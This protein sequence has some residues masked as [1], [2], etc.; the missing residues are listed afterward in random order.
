MNKYIQKLINE[1]FN[2]GNMD[3]NDKQVRNNNIFNKYT[4]NPIDVY[5]KILTDNNVFNYEIANLNDHVSVI[6]PNSKKS[7]LKIIEFYSAYYANDSLNWLD[8]SEIDD[9]GNLFYC[10][11]YN[12]DISRWDVSNVKSMWT[13][14][15]NSFFN[16]DIS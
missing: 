15:Q 10:T 6:K 13:M 4:V 5:N 11:K 8:V 16:N 12:G 3:L 7:L 9:M 14:F 1:Q 2:I